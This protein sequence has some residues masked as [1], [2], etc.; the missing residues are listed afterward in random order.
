MASLPAYF[1]DD[2]RR[3]F[4]IAQQMTYLN[5]ASISPVPLATLAV[6]NDVNTR[7]TTDPGSLLA[8]PAAGGSDIFTRFSTEIGALINAADPSE[9]VGVVS[10]SA[11]INAAAQAIDW[12][13]GDN[14]VFTDVEFPS[15][16]YPWMA[17]AR[18]GVESRT[19]AP[20]G[21]GLTVEALDA[22]VNARTRLVAVSAVQFF[23]GHRADLIALGAYCHERGILFAV[24]A[25]QAAGHIP[26]DVQAMHIDILAAGGQKSLMGP[27]GQ[28]FLY[29]RRE[30][31]ERMT[32]DGIGPT[33]VEGWEHWLHYDLTLRGG[34]QRFMMGTPNLSGMFG[35]LESIRFLRELDVAAIDDWT[36]YLSQVAINALDEL[37]CEVITPHD[38]AQLGPIVTFRV[39]TGDDLARAEAESNALM[40]HFGAHKIRLTK[41][42]DAAGW[43]HVRISTHCYNTEEEV[44]RAAA[45]LKE[46]HP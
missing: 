26:I 24:D 19:V 25:I 9:V 40:A 12:Q 29:V 18:R 7:L 21:G 31:S 36:R 15:N 30:V 16:A 23:S 6:M 4:P 46:F 20:Q 35:L 37:G 45:A 22:V 32:P 41:H 39:G 38:P 34:A 10:T 5:H 8:P 42:L 28:G 17:L 3:S 33:A 2:V 43:P 27:P 14:V 44:C 11:G 1:L 13:P